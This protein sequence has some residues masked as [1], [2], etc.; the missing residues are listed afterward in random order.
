MLFKKNIS[1]HT[2]TRNS[3]IIF[4]KNSMLQDFHSFKYLIELMV[5]F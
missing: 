3:D 2:Q 5:R 4:I 1:V